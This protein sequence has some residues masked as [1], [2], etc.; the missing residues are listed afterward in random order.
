[1]NTPIEHTR[2]RRR[3]NGTHRW[4]QSSR[5]RARENRFYDRV[6]EVGQFIRSCLLERARQQ[7]RPADTVLCEKEIDLDVHMALFDTDGACQ[8]RFPSR[9]DPANIDDRTLMLLETT[10][11]F[12]LPAYYHY[13]RSTPFP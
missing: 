13:L 4:S 1:M 10:R 3:F 6:S 8:N 11:S 5:R 7:L 9:I 12:L 2:F